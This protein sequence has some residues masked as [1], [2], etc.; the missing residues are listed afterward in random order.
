MN[1]DF[2]VSVDFFTHHK[3]RKLRKRLGAAALLSL[4]Q[5]WAYAARVRTDGDLAG[6]DAEAI[7]L[8]AEWEGE[9]GVFCATLLDIGFLDQVDDGLILHDWAEN[10]PWAAE[11]KARRERAQKGAQA[12]WKKEK[13]DPTPMLEQCSSNAQAWHP[14]ASSNA[15]SPSPKPK[16]IKA[17]PYPP[18]GGMVGGESSQDFPPPK[19]KAREPTGNSLSELRKAIADYTTSELLCKTLEDFR[20]M[21][22]RIRK[23]MTGQALRLL[24]RELDKLTGNDDALKIAILEQSIMNSW[25]GVF[26]LKGPVLYGQAS[27]VLNKNMATTAAVLAS[28]QQRRQGQ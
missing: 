24:L 14:Q 17:P 10:N 18:Q 6:M 25:Q 13:N 16:D 8:A 22:E 9:D 5:L 2:R 21:R 15:P 26:A 3:A 4:L 23:P 28:R 19:G 27:Q 12:R 11:E 20:L 1:T 7:E